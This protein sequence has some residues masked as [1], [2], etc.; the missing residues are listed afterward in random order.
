[1]E[2]WHKGV[3]YFLVSLVSFP[4]ASFEHFP[5]RQAGE[6]TVPLC[7][8]VRVC[9]CI[10]LIQ[11][12][13]LMTLRSWEQHELQ[14]VARSDRGGFF[15][16]N[17]SKVGTNHVTWVTSIP[18]FNP[19]FQHLSIFPGPMWIV[20]CG[21]CPTRWRGLFWCD[22]TAGKQERPAESDGW[23]AARSQGN[24]NWWPQKKRGGINKTSKTGCEKQPA[25]WIYM[26]MPGCHISPYV[27]RTHS[28]SR[29]CAPP[30][31]C[32]ACGFLVKAVKQHSITSTDAQMLLS[33]Q[34]QTEH[35][36][37]MLP[38]SWACWGI[39]KIKVITTL[40]L[41]NC[42]SSGHQHTSHTHYSWCP[43]CWLFSPGGGDG[44][45]SVSPGH[46]C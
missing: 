35:G 30:L 8:I 39:S 37:F 45:I 38:H 5:G 12:H 16:E 9:L 19:C 22:L 7:V 41:N 14:L 33:Q 27:P 34:R 42:D 40:T 43:K 2:P 26:C 4:S 13:I 25:F 46:P 44:F 17:V 36:L 11:V 15:F 28:F 29:W 6:V 23:A 24:A 20:S 18:S 32:L 21:V 3:I 31:W 10:H 1:M